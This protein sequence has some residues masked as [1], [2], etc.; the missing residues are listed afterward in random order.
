MQ[1]GYLCDMLCI[2]F[3][4]RRTVIH[5]LYILQE[6][7]YHVGIAILCVHGVQQCIIKCA[8]RGIKDVGV[9]F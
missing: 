7:Q 8:Q 6:E 9:N 2:H 4:R 1:R 3:V 5:T